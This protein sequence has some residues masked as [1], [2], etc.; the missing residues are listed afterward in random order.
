MVRM[1]EVADP[2]RR[3]RVIMVLAVCLMVVFAARLVYVQGIAGP[4]LAQDALTLRLRNP[5]TIYAPRGEIFDATGSLFATAVETYDIRANLNQIPDYRLRDPDDRSIIG[6]GAMAAADQLISVLGVPKGA[7][8]QAYRAEFA[9]S[10]VGTNGYHLVA[11]GVAPEI[12]EKVRDLRINGIYAETKHQREYP[13][14]RVAGSLIGF[15]DAAGNG[16]AG[17]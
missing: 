1:T 2:A 6:Y 13:N 11:A 4:A 12:W 8:P 14:D 3:Q 15:V 10:L 7:D 16:A 9:A 17:L 5:E